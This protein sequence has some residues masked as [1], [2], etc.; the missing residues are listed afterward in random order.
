MAQLSVRVPDDMKERLEEE[1]TKDRRSVAFIVKE[2]IQN[3]F[4]EVDNKEKEN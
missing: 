4:N 3:Y 1:A 2:A